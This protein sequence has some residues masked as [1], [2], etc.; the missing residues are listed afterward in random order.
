MKTLLLMGL[1]LMSGTLFAQQPIEMKVWP[2][3]APNDNGITEEKNGDTDSPSYTKEAIL[4]VYPAKKGNGMAIVACPGGG[5]SHLAMAHE[6]KSMADWFNSQGITYAVLRYRMPNGHNEVP[7]SDSQQALRIMR[8]HAQEWNVKKLGIMGS[9]AGGHLASTTA[10]HFT[11]AETRPDFQILSTRSSPRTLPTLI[12]VL[13][14][15]C[16]ERI[17]QRNWNR[18]IPMNCRLLHKHPLPSFCT[19]A[20]IQPYQW[21]TA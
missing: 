21:P 18:N 6:G 15:T 8:Q 16:W 13:T 2:N 10:T 19:A 11:D 20:M 12:E 3:G 1:L 5:Y 7:L 17:P 9:S 4:Y 14:T